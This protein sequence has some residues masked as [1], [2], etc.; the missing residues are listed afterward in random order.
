MASELTGIERQLVL[1]YL[2]DGNV[3]VTV[4]PVENAPQG[5]T[6]KGVHEASRIFPVALRAAQMTVLNQGIIL[7]KDAPESVQSFDG[8]QVRVQFYFNKLGLYFVTTLKRTSTALALV[9]PAVIHRV[10]DVAEP[11]QSDCS[12]V[13]YYETGSRTGSVHVACGF[14]GAYPLFTEPRWSDVD[15]SEQRAA[16]AYL[17]KAVASSRSSGTAI[18]NGLF[19]IPVCRYLAHD[20]A[21]DAEIRA[22]ADHAAPPT[23]LYVSHERI[24]LGCTLGG[25]RLTAGSEYA[26]KLGFPLQ[27]PVRER[28]VYLT[29]RA[30]AAYESDDGKRTCAVCRYTSIKE[31]DVRFLYDLYARKETQDE[32]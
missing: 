22:N 23:V 31:E 10:Q 19:L 3:P 9:I 18:G 27:T 30:E 24:V 4:T 28:T 7:L 8:K 1:E 20:A 16:K 29:C 26:L 5:A 14:D 15:E 11:H 12:A 25:Y 13:L 6:G 2:M 21:E 32:A 17:E